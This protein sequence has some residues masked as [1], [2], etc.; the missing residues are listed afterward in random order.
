MAPAEPPPEKFE[1]DVP[2][3]EERYV[4]GEVRLRMITIKIPAEGGRKDVGQAKKKAEKISQELLN[5]AKF[6]EL[7]K[8]YSD[9][10]LA[11]KGGDLGF[12]AYKDMVPQFQQV[13]QR[14]KIGQILGPLQS[15]DGILIFYLDEAKNRKTTQVPIPEKIRKKL[16]EEQ[17]KQFEK[18][19]ADRKRKSQAPEPERDVS[20]ADEVSSPE[21]RDSAAGKSKPS[22]ILTPEE[23]MEFKKVRDK[24]LAIV[25]T[26]KINERMREWIEELKKSSIIDV[27]L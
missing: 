1:P 2:T 27:K 16:I 12:M 25:R 3:H 24:V 22:G 7:A 23:E 6:S 26:A 8:K 20:K 13:V 17:R 10:P 15:K 5:G 18:R 14:M 19:L 21:P 9:D 11:S 4:G